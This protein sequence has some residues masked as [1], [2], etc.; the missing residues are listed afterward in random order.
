MRRVRPRCA[1]SRRRAIVLGAFGL[2]GGWN[3]T[4][5]P[6]SGRVTATNVSYNASLA[7]GASV[8]ARIFFDK[9]RRMSRIVS[10]TQKAASGAKRIV[11]LD[12]HTGLGAYGDFTMQTDAVVG[13]ILAALDAHGLAANTLMLIAT[14]VHGVHYVCDIF[15][16]LA[17][18]VVAI[19]MAPPM[20]IE[21]WR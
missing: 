5:S 2:T 6:A 12:F 20:A 17:V 14:P 4:Y 1:I 8:K 13:K 7:P 11:H 21:K 3:A 10:V 9:V 18:A 15:A 16:G 19:A